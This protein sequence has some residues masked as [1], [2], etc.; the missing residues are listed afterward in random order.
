MGLKKIRERYER[1]ER[2]FEETIGKFVRDATAINE[3]LANYKRLMDQARRMLD[4]VHKVESN[5]GDFFFKAQKA[6]PALNTQGFVEFDN[7]KRLFAVA[8]ENSN[9]P[10]PIKLDEI[11]SLHKDCKQAIAK[12]LQASLDAYTNSCVANWPPEIR[13]SMVFKNREGQLFEVTRI[14]KDP[15][16]LIDY[17]GL[18]Q[19]KPDQPWGPAKKTSLELTARTGWKYVRLPS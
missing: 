6:V 18:L 17:D 12:K 11:N 16:G 1:E 19:K 2:A 5:A 10:H 15:R 7:V 3:C 9:G 14:H 4:E 8:L 13:E